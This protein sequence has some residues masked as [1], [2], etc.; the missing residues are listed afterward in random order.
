MTGQRENSRRGLF[1][2]WQSGNLKISNL[3]YGGFYSKER[4]ANKLCNSYMV[5]G[6]HIYCFYVILVVLLDSRESGWERWTKNTAADIGVSQTYNKSVLES[7]TDKL[8]LFVHA[9]AST[10]VVQ[11]NRSIFPACQLITTIG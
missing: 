4:F 8:Q 3:K 5:K 2:L 10:R 7:S 6:V 11:T 9:H 1:W